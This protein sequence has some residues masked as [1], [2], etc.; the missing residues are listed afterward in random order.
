MNR[1]IKGDFHNYISVPLIRI[2]DIFLETSYKKCG[3]KASLKAFSKI[4]KLSI[5]LDQQFEILYN[6]S[7]L[8]AQFEYYQNTLKLRC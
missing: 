4:P 8:S 1:S 3:G 6:L 7:L 5:S 2:Y